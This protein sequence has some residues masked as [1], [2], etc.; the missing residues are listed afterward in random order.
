MAVGAPSYKGFR[1]PR[2]IISHCVWLY[3]RFPL[4]FREVEEMMLERGVVVSHETIRQ[5]CAKF[6]QSYA[7]G[8]R[9]RRAQPGNKWH[10]D[11]VFI[12]I[13]GTL[14]YLWRVVDQHD[15][16]L[17]ILVQPRRNAKAAKRFFRRLLKGLCYV[18]RVVITDKLASYGA[19]HREVMSSVEHRRSK[20]L[21]NRAENS[22]QPTR[23]RKRAMK[24]F[25]SP[26]HAQRFLSAF[27][28]ISPH[29]RPRRHRL[30]ADDYR[31]ETASR[32]TT[33]NEIT[34]LKAAA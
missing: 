34:G 21:N 19:A 5:W 29:F 7:N 1:F 2:G 33:W 25:T 16:V 20:Y 32:F 24:R 12:K 27:S 30:G 10:L 31:R 15:E 9:R 26:G 6:G 3:H 23:Q 28:G 17:D 18:P 14:H 11:E 8:L 13:N 4:S 22:H